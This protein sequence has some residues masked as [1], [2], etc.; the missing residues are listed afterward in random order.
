MRSVLLA[1]GQRTHARAADERERA[2]RTG[3]E[4]RCAVARVALRS[5]HGESN[6]RGHGRARQQQQ[7]GAA[8][9]VLRCYTPGAPAP[10]RSCARHTG[11]HAATSHHSVSG[12]GRVARCPGT[13][14]PHLPPP[15]RP[16]RHTLAIR[17]PRKAQPFT[18]V[19][20]P[21]ADR[22]RNPRERR[23]AHSSR[24]K[25]TPTLIKRKG[26]QARPL[27][28]PSDPN[29]LPALMGCVNLAVDSIPVLLYYDPQPLG[30]GATLR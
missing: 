7:R 24:A 14:S 26:P 29:P 4:P 23:P 28:G 22:H 27:E 11:V 25:A 1:A 3:W 16:A 8:L 20:Y 5:R 21:R 6:T 2:D 18:F 19:N 9:L 10:D 17:P 12:A 13:A 15:S 30:R